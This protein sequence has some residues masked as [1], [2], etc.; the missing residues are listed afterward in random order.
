MPRASGTKR[1]EI[2]DASVGLLKN[3]SLTTW[4]ID[5]CARKAHCAKGLVIHY[6]ASREKLLT[7]S[8][9]R[10]VDGRMAAWRIALAGAGIGALDLLW[11]R[12]AEEAGDGSGRALI[13]LRAAGVAGSALRPA[14]AAQLTNA[15]ARA[16]EAPATGLPTPLALE[17][18]LEGYLLALIGTAGAA[19][20]RDAFFRY[21]LSYVE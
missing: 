10:L 3:Q 11:D 20:V 5:G 13:E 7:E 15:L 2:L 4:S 6:F 12:L 8:A 17:P 1:A 19:E 14:D 9:G 18:I 16:L 21:W